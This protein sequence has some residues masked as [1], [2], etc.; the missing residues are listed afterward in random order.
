MG[1]TRSHSL[2]IGIV[3][4]PNSGKSTLF[5]SLTENSVPAENF[6]F[7]TI[8]KNV[9]VV[10][11]PDARLDKM[12]VF[13]NAQKV[14]P[15]AM[16]F[17]DIAGLVKGASQG[18]GLG[19]QFLSHI[20]EVDVILYVLRAFRSEKIIHVYDRIDPWDD[21]EIVQAELILKDIEVLERFYHEYIKRLKSG[22]TDDEHKKKDLMESILKWL[23]EGKPIVEMKLSEDDM[24]FVN[25]LALLSSKKRMFLLNSR[26]GIE[27]EEDFSKN[28][29]SH[30]SQD[31]QN[32]VI[33]MDVKT[34]GEFVG[35]T[36]EEK[37]EMLSLMNSKPLLVED[38]IAL[39]YERLNL[40]TF[41]TGNEKECNAWSVVRGANI[42]EAAGVIHTD[43]MN[44]F[45]SADVVN[46]DKVI[47][48]GGWNKAKE[49]GEVK[50]VSKD[51]L[52]CD[53]D[54]IVVL[55]NA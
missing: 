39:A 50:N 17:I 13:Y 46:V 34:I 28:C 32:F 11:I 29:L 36:K 21:F 10:K 19:N 4:L 23:G 31:D 15:G 20:R 47:D 6:P 40:I 48:L 33:K 41:Y 52:G 12:A 14:V 26:E 1:V 54:Y 25:E 22:G 27:E 24:D 8:D 53:G 45:I 55:A 3:G 18:E 42:R 16:T 43:L 51:Y 49:H 37:D 2:S 7:C 44:N 30:L 35:L 9:G 5:N 38:L